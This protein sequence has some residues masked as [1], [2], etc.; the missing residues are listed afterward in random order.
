M[1]D[2]FYFLQ[3]HLYTVAVHRLLHQKINGFQY[4]RDFGGVFYFF[5]RGVTGAA[6]D[7]AGVYFDKP[8]HALVSALDHLLIANQKR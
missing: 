7:S 3:Y 6:S 5:L 1:L 8:D 4:D 2:D